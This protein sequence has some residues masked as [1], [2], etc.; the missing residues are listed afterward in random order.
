MFPRVYWNKSVCQS[1][2]VT[3]CMYKLLEKKAFENSVG[4]GE[5]AGN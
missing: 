2:C 3:V 5:N 1:L 4:K